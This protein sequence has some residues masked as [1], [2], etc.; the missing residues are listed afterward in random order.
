M[1]AKFKAEETYRIIGRGVVISGRILEGTIKIGM[2]VSIPKV[3]RVLTIAGIGINNRID[4]V[5]GTI[6]LLFATKDPKEIKY[7]RSLNLQ[8]VVLEITETE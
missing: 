5:R 4:G 1:A 7:L 8:D 3:D 2:Q 6:S